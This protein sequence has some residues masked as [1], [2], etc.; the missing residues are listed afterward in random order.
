[1]AASQNNWS[2]LKEKP[3]PGSLTTI[4]LIINHEA[5]DNIKD[6]VVIIKVFQAILLPVC[7]QNFSSSGS[8]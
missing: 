5:K 6:K 4:T 2:L 7:S 3:N 1:M 8:H